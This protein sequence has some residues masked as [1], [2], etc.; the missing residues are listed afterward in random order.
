MSIENIQ[1]KRFLE[2]I[3][4]M[5]YALG[6]DPSDS[7]ISNLYGR[8]FARFSPG[9]SLNVPYEDLNSQSKIDQDTLNRIMVHIIYNVDV[10]YESFYDQSEEL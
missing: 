5:Y 10:L 4:K 1:K 7:E 3:Y 8:Y 9:S 6:S 2:T